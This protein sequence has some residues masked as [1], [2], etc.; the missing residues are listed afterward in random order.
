MIIAIGSTN[1]AKVRAV[2]SAVEAVWF[3]AELVPVAVPSGVSA[4]PMTAEEGRRGASE[5]ARQALQCTPGAALGIGLEGAVQEED[6]TLYLTNWVAVLARDGR[7][8]LATGG[9]LPLPEIIARELRAGGELG[10][11]MDRLTGEQDTKHGLGAA[12][13][14]TR[15][16]VPRDLTFRVGV[17]LALAPFLRPEWYEA[18]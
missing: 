12:G 14:L 5:R 1:R 16:I 18:E 7:H 10:P 6:G 9:S 17:G 4:M 15:G 13:I 2:Q 3:D 8:S 11:I